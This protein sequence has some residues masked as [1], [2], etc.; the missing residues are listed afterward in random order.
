MNTPAKKSKRRAKKV[1]IETELFRAIHNLDFARERLEAAKQLNPP[2]EENPTDDD[3]DVLRLRRDDH[4]KACDRV[5]KA[6]TRAINAIPEDD[7]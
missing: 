7:Q 6:A 5:N 3:R 1:N 4:R 2:F